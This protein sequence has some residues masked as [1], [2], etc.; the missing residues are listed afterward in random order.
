MKFTPSTV[1]IYATA[2]HTTRENGILHHIRVPSYAYGAN[3]TV[4]KPSTWSFY[5]ITPSAN[6][7][8]Y[9]DRIE[10]SDVIEG[11]YDIY[12]T[13][14]DVWNYPSAELPQSRVNFFDQ[15]GTLIPFDTF[16]TYYA[17]PETGFLDDW[18]MEANEPEDDISDLNLGLGYAESFADIS[19]WAYGGSTNF[20]SRS[21]SSD[22][23]I[24]T[25]SVTF[26][27]DT[28]NG[29]V[30]YY[31]DDVNGLSLNDFPFIEFK[32]S[33]ETDANTR[34]V[35]AASYS[36]GTDTVYNKVVVDRY[37]DF[38]WNIEQYNLLEHAKTFLEGTS[39]TLVD[40][41]F[42]ID[43]YP[44][45][46]SQTAT[47][48]VDWIRVYGYTDYDYDQR[49]VSKVDRDDYVY[50]EDGRITFSI[51]YS[52]SGTAEVLR[53]YRPIDISLVDYPYIVMRAKGDVY[54]AVLID[55]CWRGYY[56]TVEDFTTIVIDLSVKGRRAT[57]LLIGSLDDASMTNITDERITIPS[58]SGRRETTYDYIAFVE[59]PDFQPLLT[60]IFEMPRYGV[61]WIY[62]EDRWGTKV[63]NEPR[64]Y[65]PFQDFTVTMYSFQVFNFQEDFIYVKVA[66]AGTADW[67]GQYLGPWE[68]LTYS[69]YPNDYDLQISLPNGT[70]ISDTF[71][72]NNDTAYLVSGPTLSWVASD[73]KENTT[74][75]VW[76]AGDFVVVRVEGSRVYRTAVRFFDQKGNYVPFETFFTYYNVSDVELSAEPTWNPMYFD[77]FL[78]G[79]DQYFN[80]KVY[81]RWGSLLLDKRNQT[82]REFFNFTITLYSWKL[83]NFQDDFVY[84]QLKR[85]EAS[86]WYTEWIAPGEIEEEYLAPGWYNLTIQF[87]N[88]TEI[89]EGF[90]LNTDATYIVEGWTLRKLAGRVDINFSHL[91]PI[92]LR[93]NY[94]NEELAMK[95]VIL[96][97]NGHQSS[98]RVL[99]IEGNWANI[100]VYDVFNHLLA[101]KKYNVT[102]VGWVNIGLN[103]THLVLKNPYEIYGVRIALTSQT[104][105]ASRTFYIPPLE[106]VDTFVANDTYNYIVD[107]MD[108]FFT[109]V[110][111]TVQGS[112]TIET[113]QLEY[114][115]LFGWNIFPDAY[116]QVNFVGE[117]GTINL[118]CGIMI[119]MNYSKLPIPSVYLEAYV[120]NTLAGTGWT[121]SQG[122]AAIILGKPLNGSGTLSIKASKLGVTRWYNTT[123][124]IWGWMTV[125]EPPMV[126]QGEVGTY[127]LIFSNPS[128]VGDTPIKIEN[129]TVIFKV[130]GENTTAP[131]LVINKTTIDI[132]AGSS[133]FTFTLNTTDLLPGK[134]ILEIEVIYANST[135]AKKQIPLT[136]TPRP[137]YR[138]I[139]PWWLIIVIL[140]IVFAASLAA[141]LIIQWSTK[142]KMAQRLHGKKIIRPRGVEKQLSS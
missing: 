48:Y 58:Y 100:T 22:G 43:D 35:V 38:N 47:L 45:D 71:T 105:G 129:A 76:E 53:L 132:P 111:R 61:V 23:D 27:S 67:F 117:T 12:F 59:E 122:R 85:A 79:K 40:L 72:L 87:K 54:F 49:F 108:P 14:R 70:V 77:V 21:V 37:G 140:L 73:V 118:V 36:N 136:V 15:K 8:E 7:V 62:A 125:E 124:S 120:N 16:H 39:F 107:L 96:Y 20:D 81:D 78:M 114:I 112:F 31:T 113:G 66:K 60:N 55:G 89:H 139:L 138:I 41:R 9:T 34:F 6:V 28:V 88:G 56:R 103:V 44:N 92:S 83:I 98:D 137:E 134:Y 80:I 25:F 104:T 65:S 19:D 97:V 24:L 10:I 26:P 93:N 106:T 110:K 99:Y 63:V 3:I 2:D 4:Y 135:F 127:N 119:Y 101:D 11:D 75:E 130:Y 69:L 141:W 116:M 46:A 90:Y 74:S 64:T 5:N 1:T 17:L 51:Y 30:T 84:M 42:I 131:F 126:T 52:Q 33:G 128:R 95:H 102:E 133:Q 91:L 50:V 94:T 68:S 13:S 115:I 86:N 121:D 32:W 18:F 123:Y 142:R 82:Y 109:D 57:A 29:W